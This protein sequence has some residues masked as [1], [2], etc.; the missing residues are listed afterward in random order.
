LVVDF[1]LV[2]FLPELFELDLLPI[3][4]AMALDLLS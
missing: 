2:D 3:F 4:F 1:L